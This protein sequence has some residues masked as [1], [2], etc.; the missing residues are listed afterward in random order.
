MNQ[1]IEDNMLVSVVIPTYRRPQKLNRAIQSVLSQTYPYFEILIADDNEPGSIW[2]YR[3]MYVIQ[4][5]LDDSRVHCLPCEKHENGSAARNRGLSAARGTWICFL[6]DDDYYEPD[7][8]EKQIGFLNQHSE[9]SEN[10]SAARNRGLSA[11]R[12]TW[13]CFLDDDDYYEPDKLE[14][15]IG[16]LNQHSEFSGCYCDYKRNGKVEQIPDYKDLCRNILLRKRIPQTSSWLL[17]TE[18]VRAIGGF[19]ESY[20]RYQDYEFLMRY[21]QA[22]YRLGKV[23]APLYTYSQ[24]DRLNIPDPQELE[25]LNMKFLSEFTDRLAHNTLIRQ[26]FA[27]FS[28]PVARIYFQNQRYGDSLRL[29]SSSFFRAPGTTVVRSARFLFH[30]FQRPIHSLRKILSHENFKP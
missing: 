29:I 25:R 14:K 24:S 12:G 7:K 2:R 23:A 22:G 30:Q 27:A 26:S 1:E 4:S 11:A 9:F 5:Y 6:D 21:D 3:T 28:L 13:I 17:R 19:D 16:F 18:I 15:Q 20:P 8:L 10:G